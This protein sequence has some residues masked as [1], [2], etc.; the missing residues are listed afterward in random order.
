MDE[1]ESKDPALWVLPS[2]PTSEADVVDAQT[3]SLTV[4]D[5]VKDTQLW[6]DKIVEG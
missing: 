1:R 2:Y 4:E 6:L 3:P 5:T